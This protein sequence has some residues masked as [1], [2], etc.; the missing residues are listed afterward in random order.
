[1]AFSIGNGRREPQGEINVTPLIDIVLVL[2][3]IFMVMT[4]VTLKELVAKVPQ[5][6]TENV[7][8]PPGD[9]PI[10]VELDKHDALTLNGE[11]VPPEA[12]AE[13]VAERLLHDRQKV[14]FFKIDDDA[15][16]DRAVRIMDV[17]KGAGAQTLGIVTRD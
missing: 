8:Q 15:S 4:P 11:A 14:V 3:I 10:V 13:R 16:Y 2:L 9:N 1:M 17:C 7:P 5:K 12:L 6:Q